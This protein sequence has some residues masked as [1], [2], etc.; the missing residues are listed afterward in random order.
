MKFRNPKSNQIYDL[1]DCESMIDGFCYNIQCGKCPIEE[2]IVNTTCRK[3]VYDHPYEAARLMGY[4]ILDDTPS[5]KVDTLTKEE[6]IKEIVE[7][8]IKYN[9]TLH[10]LVDD[11][12]YEIKNLY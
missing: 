7:M 1:L 11:F 5:V 10:E 8:I 2:K 4:E 9:I 6:A 12:A 3:W